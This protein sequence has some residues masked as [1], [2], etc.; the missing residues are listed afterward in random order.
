MFVE[1]FEP[2]KPNN[3]SESLCPVYFFPFSSHDFELCDFYLCDWAIYDIGKQSHKG[4]LLILVA[5]EAESMVKLI[6]EYFQ[7][8][9]NERV[10][11]GTICLVCEAQGTYLMA[12]KRERRDL[13][14]EAC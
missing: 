7:A 8:K 6:D 11:K 2:I 9:S 10:L 13:C 3:S 14:E 5:I 12:E 4:S 1:S